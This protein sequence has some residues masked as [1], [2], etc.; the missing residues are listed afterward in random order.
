MFAVKK[1]YLKDKL[2]FH[3]QMKDSI[4][5]LFIITVED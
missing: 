2:K 4:F 3:D 1:S 5:D